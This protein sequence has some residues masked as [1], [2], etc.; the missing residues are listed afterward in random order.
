M[1]WRHVV[2][3][4]AN[5]WPLSLSLLRV[6]LQNRQKMRFSSYVN[7]VPVGET[8]IRSF[9]SPSV[10]ALMFWIVLFCLVINVRWLRL[11][12]FYAR[13]EKQSQLSSNDTEVD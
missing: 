7:F 8:M 1:N 5:I 12:T 11:I 6:K 2:G 9:L 4:G 3:R 10:V 13:N